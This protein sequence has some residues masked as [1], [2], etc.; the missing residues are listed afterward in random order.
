MSQKPLRVIN[1]LAGKQKG[2][3]LPF[4]LVYLA[5]CVTLMMA[6]LDRGILALRQTFRVIQRGQ[7]LDEMSQDLALLHSS[8]AAAAAAVSLPGSMSVTVA[9]GVIH[10]DSVAVPYTIMMPGEQLD[11]GYCQWHQQLQA[12]A[13]LAP[14]DKSRSDRWSVYVC[15]WFETN[16]QAM[17][18][19]PQTYW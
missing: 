10:W 14:S 18:Y 12:Q 5:L 16:E 13:N 19:V 15:E 2:W 11:K 9:E 6:E 4:C 8:T 17:L 3:L 7:V 1:G